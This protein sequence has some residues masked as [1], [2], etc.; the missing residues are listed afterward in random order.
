MRTIVLILALVGWLP[1]AAQPVPQEFT[2]TSQPVDGPYANRRFSVMTLT[3][4]DVRQQ[5]LFD[6]KTSLIVPIH[7]KD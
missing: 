6:T 3:G 4:P 1:Q 5:F 7:A 2:M